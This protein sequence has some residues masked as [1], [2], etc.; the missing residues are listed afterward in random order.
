MYFSNT[1]ARRDAL[2]DVIMSAELY[3]HSAVEPGADD[4]SRA[5]RIDADAAPTEVRCHFAGQR[6]QRGLRGRIGRAGERMHPRPGDRGDVDHRAAGGGRK[7]TMAHLRDVLRMTG[8]PRGAVTVLGAKKAFPVIIDDS[9]FTPP[10]GTGRV[11]LYAY[12]GMTFPGATC[13]PGTSHSCANYLWSTPTRLDKYNAIIAPCD[14]AS[15]GLPAAYNPYVG[16]SS[17]SS[18]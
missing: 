10:S 14:K 3:M 4:G 9:E 7:A 18:T 11:H 5:D 6:R 17:S 1:M 2:A 16:C 12:N 13:S 8:Y 15:S